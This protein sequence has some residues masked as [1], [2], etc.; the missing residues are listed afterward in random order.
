MT[1]ESAVIM[2]IKTFG[3]KIALTSCK[4]GGR[5]AWLKPRN[6]LKPRKSGAFEMVGCICHTDL[7]KLWR[8]ECKKY[9]EECMR[10]EG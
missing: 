9:I 5:Y 7:I 2:L 10:R 6:L 8:K 1:R 4:C 3:W